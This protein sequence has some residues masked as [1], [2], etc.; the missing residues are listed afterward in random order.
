MKKLHL[1]INYRLP[2]DFEGD[3]NDAIEHMLNYRRGEKDHKIDFKYDPH[4]DIYHNW[5]DMVNTTDRVLL[6]VYSLE[7]LVNDEWI[8]LDPVTDSAKCEPN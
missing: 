6:G 8:D 2:D 7:E 4:K 1:N 5:W 3:T